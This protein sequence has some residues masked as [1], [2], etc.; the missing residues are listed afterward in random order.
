MI[1]RPARSRSLMLVLGAL[2][3]A[4]SA[5]SGADDPIVA[6]KLKGFDEYMV[7]VLKDWNVPG[8]GVGVLPT[9]MEA[10]HPELVPVSDPIPEL[11]QPVWIVT[12]P[13]LRQTARVRAFMQF[14]GD[15]L[16]QRLR[17]A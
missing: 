16:V 9:F 4:A 7:K 12:H 14:V 17:A 11:A 6:K 1:R 2:V 5:A 15:A 3:L 8:I 13:D 10:K